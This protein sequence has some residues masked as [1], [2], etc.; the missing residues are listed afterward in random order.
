[1]KS[2]KTFI[3]GMTLV[4]MM[5]SIVIF[6][7]IANLSYFYLKKIEPANHDIGYEITAI[8][9]RARA[10]SQ[11]SI[12]LAE[13]CDNG[14]KH[15]AYFSS[16]QIILFEGESW[17]NRDEAIDE[18]YSFDGAIT[19][20]SSQVVFEQLTGSTPSSNQIIFTD[21]TGNETVI[22]INEQGQIDKL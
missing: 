3:R 22:E 20:S 10:L 6:T 2:R 11:N 8:L 16:N 21:N 4:E 1:M 9:K 18:I 14:K 19:T 17:Q 12:C 7:V 5:I 13:T 15:G